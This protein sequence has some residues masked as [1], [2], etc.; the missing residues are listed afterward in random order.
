MITSIKKSR[1]LNVLNEKWDNNSVLTDLAEKG[2][3]TMLTCKANSTPGTLNYLKCCSKKI[4]KENSFSGI[5][6]VSLPTSAEL[7]WVQGCRL[8]EL[9][10]I[11]MM[12]SWLIFIPAC[13][14]CVSRCSIGKVENS[15]ILTLNIM[16]STEGQSYVSTNPWILMNNQKA[17]VKIR[18]LGLSL[19]FSS[20]PL[21]TFILVSFQRRITLHRPLKGRTNMRNCFKTHI[22]SMYKQK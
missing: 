10:C 17:E 6:C 15:K 1:L 4:V 12:D 22:I 8:Q 20:S 18:N 13:W 5:I 3:S 16:F 9:M 7:N 14:I 19:N 21:N 2:W 11:H